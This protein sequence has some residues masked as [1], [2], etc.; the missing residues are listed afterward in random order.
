MLTLLAS[1][2]VLA[3]FLALAISVGT[4]MPEQLPAH[5][6]FALGAMPLITAAMLHFVPVLTRSGPP[7]PLIR[8]LPW[9]V[10]AGGALA[11]LS[12]KSADLWPWG[13]LLALGT[14]LLAML[15]L[16]FWALARGRRCLGAPHPGLWWYPAALA[17]LCLGLLAAMVM[18]TWSEAYPALRLVHLHLNLLGFIG[19]TAVGTLQVLMPTALGRPDPGAAARLKKDLPSALFGVVLI[20]SGAGLSW[21]AWSPMLPVLFWGMGLMLWLETLQRLGRAW[22]ALAGLGLFARD[23]AAASLAWAGAGLAAVSL[24][25]VGHSGLFHAIGWSGLAGNRAIMGFILA[26]M[27]P[28]V[29]GALAYLLPLWRRPGRQTAWHE[30]QR[31]RLGAYAGVRGVLFVTSGLAVT[32]GLRLAL[33]LAVPALA[34]FAWRLFDRKSWQREV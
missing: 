30:F 31:R 7:H 21:V 34:Q 17:C 1:T 18:V 19:L 9:P 4:S 14:V 3:F 5:L 15:C 22:W 6:V 20:A 2:T 25:A 24:L 16:L 10:L 13:V 27:L 33:L 23:G 28:L 26:F 12:F 8:L 11:S 32:L 29:S